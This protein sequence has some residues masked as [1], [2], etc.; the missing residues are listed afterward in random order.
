VTVAA[1]TVVPAVRAA[2]LPAA[3]AWDDVEIVRGVLVDDRPPR[4]AAPLA[5]RGAAYD[6]GGRPAAADRRGSLVSV[7]A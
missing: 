5:A 1:P 7:L 3:D 4:P 6:R 2:A